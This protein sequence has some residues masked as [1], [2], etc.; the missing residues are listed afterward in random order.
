MKSILPL[1]FTILLVSCQQVDRNSN[2]K[3]E[4]LT[5]ELEASKV[6]LK[7]ATADETGFIHTVFF[8]LNEGVTDA[9]KAD[10]EKN[11][12]GDLLK[13]TSIYKSYIGPPAQTS[14]GVIDNTYDFALVCHF[15]NA[16]DEKSYQVDPIHL[17]FIESYEKLWTKVVVY[18]NLVSG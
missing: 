2:E 14:R 12:L 9:E 10:F 11:G 13:I 18:D 3:I 7:N 6:A 15:K 1:I 16:E 5:N 17:K 4:E 8:W